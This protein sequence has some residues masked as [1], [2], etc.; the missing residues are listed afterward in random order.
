[1][2]ARATPGTSDRR[3]VSAAA[4]EEFFTAALAN[5][6]SILLIIIPRGRRLLKISFWLRHCDYFE[7]LMYV[8]V[9]FNFQNH[10]VPCQND[11]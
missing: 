9:H 5:A 4:P 3:L 11:F 2:A 7:S 1:M 10:R 6:S 8:F